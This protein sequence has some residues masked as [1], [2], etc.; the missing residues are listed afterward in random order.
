MDESIFITSKIRLLLNERVMGFLALISLFIALAPTVVATNER[1]SQAKVFLEWGILALFI[2]EYGVNFVLASSR[3]V[4]LLDPWRILDL[5]IISTGLLSLI[6]MANEHLRNIPALRL[7]K[8]IRMALFGVRMKFA[9]SLD[10]NKVST[11]SSP[12]IQ[13]FSAYS[14]VDKNICGY[15]EL[16]WGNVVK[17]LKSSSNDWLFAVGL[18]SEQLTEV[19]EILQAPKSALGMLFKHSLYP[20]I[21][22][23]DEYTAIF[24]WSPKVVKQSDDSVPT[25]ERSPI[26]L[27]GA[28]NNI[29][30]LSGTESSLVDE[31]T[32]DLMEVGIP[33]PPLMQATSA[34]IRV[35]VAQYTDVIGT[36]EQTLLY[37]DKHQKQLGDKSFLDQTF[38]LRN[39][40]TNVR[41]NLKHLASVVHQLAE[42]PLA[43]KSF[44]VMPRPILTVL[45]DDVDGLFDSADDLVT[46]LAA[47]VELRINMSSFQMNKVMRLLAVITTI[48]LIPTMVG[49]LM[50]MNLIDSPWDFTLYEVTFFVGVAMSCGIYIFASKGWF[51]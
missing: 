44:E 5:F 9:M 8:F 31:I 20:R 46:T 2:V 17:R 37:L 1:F 45:A 23:M 14:L 4:F 26:L 36:L 11:V 30:T 43:I 32:V 40:I 24:L 50:G 25:I 35:L 33:A 6:P 19:A 7:L 16:T 27:L 29:I 47:L 15:T 41:G 38:R 18:N 42:K 21:E 13:S 51:R 12:S 49:G 3:R 28:N 48:T 34:L 10:N 22:R 39:E